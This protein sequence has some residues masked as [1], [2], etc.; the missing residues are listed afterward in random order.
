[1]LTPGAAGF[2]NAVLRRVSGSSREEWLAR[3]STGDTI[4]DL[5]LVH[6]HPQWIVR[7]FVD[8]L[9]STEDAARA[10][11]A[12]N[13]APPV[14]LW[15]RPGLIDRAALGGPP[16]RYS[17]YSVVL[18]AGDPSSI[19]ALRDGRAHVQD[20]GS[21]LVT[22][23]LATAPLDGPDASWLDLCAG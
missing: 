7:S 19:P 18:A 14:P 3:L 13:A 1:S 11:A 6:A 12:A 10:L 22:T 17:P 5:A 4:G 8:S 15:P 20:E 9:G 16:G 21:Q 2:A 23:A